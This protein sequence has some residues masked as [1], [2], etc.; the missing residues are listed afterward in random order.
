MGTRQAVSLE[1]EQPP[2]SATLFGLEFQVQ[3]DDPGLPRWLTR[4]FSFDFRGGYRWL[5][6]EPY[7]EVSM[8]NNHDRSNFAM[9]DTILQS[10]N[11]SPTPQH[12]CT[13]T[14]AVPAAIYAHRSV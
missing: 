1:L 6:A 13:Q 14:A 9:T 10:E 12:P 3:P 4:E 8:P 2:S 11:E 5:G 7:S